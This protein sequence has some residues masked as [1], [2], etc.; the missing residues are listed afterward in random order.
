M[1]IET[2]NYS[3]LI[4]GILVII[5]IGIIFFISSSKDEININQNSEKSTV[6]VEGDINLDLVDTIAQEDIVTLERGFY[7]D[8][9]PEKIAQRSETGNVVLFFSAAWC[10]TCRTLDKDIRLNIKDIPVDLS[11]LDIDYDNSTVLKR[12]YGVTYQH[13][14]VQVD[15]KGELIKKWGG[16]MTLDALVS[17]VQ[18]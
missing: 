10:P 13:T 9:S 17:K 12:K 3:K 2:K 7:E 16:S 4:I 6:V 1:E 8:Y 11:I 15:K 18:K 14:L 5:L